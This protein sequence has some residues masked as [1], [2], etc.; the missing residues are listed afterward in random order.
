MKT[1]FKK[2]LDKVV[3]RVR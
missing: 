2:R 3:L 1:L